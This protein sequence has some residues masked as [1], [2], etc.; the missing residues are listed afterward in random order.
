MAYFPHSSPNGIPL[1]LLKLLF[2]CTDVNEVTVGFVPY[3]AV[4]LLSPP[5]SA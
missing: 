1:A 2:V 3:V 4:S 5:V